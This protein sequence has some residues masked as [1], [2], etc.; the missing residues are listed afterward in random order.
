MDQREIYIFESLFQHHYFAK[1]E[2]I[3]WSCS[4]Y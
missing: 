1:K 2:I 4:K 3:Q